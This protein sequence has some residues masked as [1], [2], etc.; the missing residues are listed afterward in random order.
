M[1]FVGTSEVTAV[2]CGLFGEI[3]VADANADEVLITTKISAEEV[4]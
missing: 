3:N 4:Q 1:S 2:T